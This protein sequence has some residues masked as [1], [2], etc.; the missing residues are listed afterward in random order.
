MDEDKSEIEKTCEEL[1]QFAIDRGEIASLM[2]GLPEG[3]DVFRATV[4]HELQMLKIISVGWSLSYYMPDGPLKTELTTLFWQTVHDFSRDL[5]RTTK[6]LIDQDVDF[7]D[8]IRNRFD[9]YLGE[10]QKK[11]DAPEPAV[12]IGPEFA[13]V[14]GDAGNVHVVM[15]GS[16]MFIGTVG[17]ART[18]LE[19][20]RLR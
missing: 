3:S 9:G 5:D 7:F 1:F 14:C 10:L 13:R 2:S 4:E 18:Y 15:A 8:S 11:T 20:L 17:E 19:R 12:I 6:L 16:R